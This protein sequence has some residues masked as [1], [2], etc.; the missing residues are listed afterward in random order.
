MST[1]FCVGLGL[2]VLHLNK[3]SELNQ[4]FFL[5]CISGFIYTFTTVLMWL[6]PD[7]NTALIWHKAGTIWPIFV[8]SVLH[9]ALIF[10]DNKFFKFKLHYLVLY[11]P[12]IAFSVIDLTTDLINTPPILKPW[13]YNDQASGSLLYGISTVW[14][15]LLPLLAF[16]LCLRYYIKAKEP[17]LRQRA[18]LVSI[19][20][21]I[22][23]ICFITTNMISRSLGID[24]PNF[25]PF[26]TFFLSLFVGYAITNYDLFTIDSVLELRTLHAT[27]P[28]SLVL[29]DTKGRILK[30][31]DN[32]IKP[33]V[34]AG[35]PLVNR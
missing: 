15:A 31:N 34:I 14:S 25:G 4:I 17:S 26:S 12:A 7:P 21:I 11:V 8:A 29:T 23:I 1:I 16:G 18:K 2:Y 35:R 19:G 13:G 28:S 33:Q 3:K 32:L 9:F 20:F 6:S 10:T 24:V 5:V 27:L 30:I 22:P